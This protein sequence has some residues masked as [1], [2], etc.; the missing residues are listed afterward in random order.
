MR[1]ILLSVLLLFASCRR[2]SKQLAAM[3]TPTNQSE[4]ADY[5][6]HLKAGDE[7]LAVGNEPSWSLTI[8]SSKNTLRFKSMAGDS[9]NIPVPERQA[10]SDGSFR[11]DAP[12]ESGRLKVLFALDSCVDKL[13]G[14]RFDYRVE[15]DLRGKNYLGCGV[16]LRRVALLQ[17]IWVLTDLQG[18]RITT[19]S[20][21]SEAPRLEI[22]L[23][24]GCVTG[25]T[26]CN[27][28]NGSVRADSRLIRFGPLATTKMAC[29]GDVNTIEAKLL[30]SLLLPLAYQVGEGKL[31]LLQQGKPIA[32]F[33]KVD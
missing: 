23:T 12:V 24:E 11:F 3:F 22:S 27:R 4:I 31:I 28:L 16:S 8:N 25:T 7:L 15:V 13:S 10:D 17:D 2:P 6:T 1:L 9:L 33:K 30:T 29:A 32:V 19:N 20:S 26:G 14:Q 21:K 5:T 18:Q